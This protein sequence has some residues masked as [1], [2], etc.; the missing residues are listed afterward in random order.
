MAIT[1]SLIWA[2]SVSEFTVAR[3]GAE[4]VSPRQRSDDPFAGAM[5]TTMN[6][7][8]DVEPTRELTEAEVDAVSGGWFAFHATTEAIDAVAKAL[9]SMAQKQ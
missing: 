6:K 2:Q 4:R 3:S 1:E 9:A 5:E 7:S 8:N